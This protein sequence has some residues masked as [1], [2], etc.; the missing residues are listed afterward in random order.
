M[1]FL[2]VNLDASFL[3]ADALSCQ[4]CGAEQ[5]LNAYVCTHCG[6]LFRIASPESS[7]RFWGDAFYIFRLPTITSRPELTAEFGEGGLVRETAEFGL[8]DRYEYSISKNGPE[9]TGR[10]RG[11]QT[12]EVSYHATFVD[13][14]ED[15]RL[16]KR[17][18]HGELGGKPARFLYRKVVY[19]YADDRIES[20][21]VGTWLY[22]K[23]KDWEKRPADWIRHNKVK[24]ELEYA[25]GILARIHAGRRQGVRDLRG[26]PDY[27]AEERFSEAVLVEA[28]LVTGFGQPELRVEEK[29]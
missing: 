25:D 7:N 22:A 21:D 15:G 12:K 29:K 23:A 18:V 19:R 24:I 8:G 1:S 6:R 3:A 9:I 14:H 4:F 11:L 17:E 26:N 13:H 20:A 10:V 28:E 16:V 5:S 27:E 2:A